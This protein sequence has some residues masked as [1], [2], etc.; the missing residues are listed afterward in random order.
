MDLYVERQCVDKMKGGNAKQFLLLFDAS[1]RDVYKYVARR[2]GDRAESE[3]IVRLTF[4]DALGQ[5]GNTP[6]DVSYLTWLY[7]LAKP[8]VWD[9]I[10]KESISR[11]R[12]LVTPFDLEK[13][14]NEEVVGK[15][16][17]T[18]KKMSLEEQEIL[19]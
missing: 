7:S 17:K 3:K 5:I 11:Q 10:A 2:V 16:D 14:E 13:K 8:R 19:R 15:I 18:M 12:G 9:R 1:F 6:T 4:L